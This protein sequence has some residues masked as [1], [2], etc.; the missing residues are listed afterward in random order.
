MYAFDFRKIMAE[1]IEGILWSISEEL[2]VQS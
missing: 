2:E 1:E